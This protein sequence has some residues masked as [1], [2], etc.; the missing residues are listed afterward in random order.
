M[1]STV[2][3]ECPNCERLAEGVDEIGEKFGWRWLPN[4]H[5]PNRTREPQSWCKR[6]RDAGKYSK[7]GKGS[8]NWEPE[9]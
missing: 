1:P 8:E 9:N 2:K 5:D 6:C 4:K 7:I 3:A